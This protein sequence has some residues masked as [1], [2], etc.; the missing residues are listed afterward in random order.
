[1]E[2]F[3]VID[4]ETN[5]KNKVMSIGMVIALDGTFEE[6][7]LKY[8]TLVPEIEVGGWYWY[9]P[10]ELP[11]Y[12][13]CDTR[14]CSREQAI[15][16]ILDCLQRNDVTKIFAYN[17]AFDYKHLPELNTF[18]WYD[19]MRIAAYRQYNKKIR[20]EDCCGTGRLKKNYGVDPMKKLLTGCI[21]DELHNA[22][23]DALDELNCIMK[24]L[25]YSIDDYPQYFPNTQKNKSSNTKKRNNTKKREVQ[26][27]LSVHNSENDYEV[28]KPNLNDL[29][30]ALNVLKINSNN[31][32]LEYIPNICGIVFL[33]ATAFEDDKAVVTLRLNVGGKLYDSKVNLLRHEL[34]NLLVDFAN[35]NVEG[36]V[37][38]LEM[39]TETLCVG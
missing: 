6:C 31:I 8:Y 27:K 35:R 23:C 26:V 18:A 4:T 1:M 30:N 25:G 11:H 32:I 38:I 9:A 3:A 19:I 14:E 22:L 15:A 13:K 24:P 37:S 2:K 12:I 36:V 17:A 21:E 16:D 5:M 39:P 33:E 28:M 7:E 29:L 10:F 34:R 20:A